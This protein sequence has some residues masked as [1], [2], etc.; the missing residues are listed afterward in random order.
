MAALEFP[1]E[2][3]SAMYRGRHVQVCEFLGRGLLGVPLYW[4]VDVE[5]GMAGPAYAAE[6]TDRSG[7]AIEIMDATL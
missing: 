4:V 6:L 5:D 2:I 7:T 3:S 1:E